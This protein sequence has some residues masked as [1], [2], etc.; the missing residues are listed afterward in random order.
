MYFIS[1]WFTITTTLPLRF[2]IS[3][4][5]ILAF[6]SSFKDIRYTIVCFC[7]I[8][9]IPWLNIYFSLSLF[10]FLFFLTFLPLSFGGL[11][12]RTD[13][14]W[15]SSMNI[16]SSHYRLQGT[17]PISLLFLNVYSTEPHAMYILD[18][19]YIWDNIEH[20]TFEYHCGRILHRR[21]HMRNKINAT[22]GYRKDWHDWNS[23][24]WT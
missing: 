16:F 24:R 10:P 1:T 17:Q 6:H 11:D 2:H 13:A 12:T 5:H 23:L 4:L 9:T 15:K 19:L 3:R 8:C 20:A 14:P 18:W 7:T 21:P 22:S